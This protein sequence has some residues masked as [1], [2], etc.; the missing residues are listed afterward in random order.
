MCWI[1]R[2]TIAGSEKSEWQCQNVPHASSRAR[3]RKD[4]SSLQFHKGSAARRCKD[5]VASGRSTSLENAALAAAKAAK[6]EKRASAV[7]LLCR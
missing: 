6:A 2:V 4:F 1:D 5:C 3:V 7:L